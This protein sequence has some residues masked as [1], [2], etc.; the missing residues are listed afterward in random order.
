MPTPYRKLVRD[1]IPEIIQAGGR[2][3]VTRV[4]DESGYRQAL[5]DKLVEEAGEAASASAASSSNQSNE[6]GARFRYWAARAGV[7]V[8]AAWPPGRRTFREAG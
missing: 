5:L 4:L 2:H 6:T 1:R 3:P 8:R 7:T